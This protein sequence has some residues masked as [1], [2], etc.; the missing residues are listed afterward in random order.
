MSKKKFNKMNVAVFIS[1]AGTN[2]QSLID[3]QG[4][5][6]QHGQISFVLSSSANPYGIIRAKKNNIPV[7]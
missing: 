3:A 2:L 5:V 1:G 6:L 4:K 7:L